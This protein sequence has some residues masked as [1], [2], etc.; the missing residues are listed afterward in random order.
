MNNASF[1]ETNNNQEDGAANQGERER[2][3]F[4]K[5]CSYVLARSGEAGA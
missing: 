3:F 2:V 5:S 1:L 4:Y